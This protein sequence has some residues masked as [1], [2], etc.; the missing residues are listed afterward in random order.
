MLGARLVVGPWQVS[1][2]FLH[3]YIVEDDSSNS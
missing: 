1:S 3:I 2:A